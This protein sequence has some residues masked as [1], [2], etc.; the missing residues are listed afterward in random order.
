LPVTAKQKK[1]GNWFFFI[2]AVA[3]SL[4][5]WENEWVFVRTIS[6]LEISAANDLDL[7][8]DEERIQTGAREVF[9]M[10]ELAQNVSRMG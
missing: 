2:V 5:V 9:T 8:H 10:A 6:S 7:G 3:R 1:V 4:G